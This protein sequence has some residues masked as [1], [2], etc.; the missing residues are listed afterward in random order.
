VP[1]FIGESIFLYTRHIPHSYSDHGGI[2]VGKQGGRKRSRK[3]RFE[4]KI[5]KEKVSKKGESMSINRR[6]KVGLKE[7][8]YNIL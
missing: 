5:R 6:N 7:G 3:E 4:V 1:L 8:L 2:G